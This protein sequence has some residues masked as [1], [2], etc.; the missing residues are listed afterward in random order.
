MASTI[1]FPVNE[2][3]FQS[4]FIKS[5]QTQIYFLDAKQKQ[6]GYDVIKV[7]MQRINTL[8]ITEL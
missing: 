8:M 5:Q 6:I 1:V 3:D 2:T 4:C 7:V